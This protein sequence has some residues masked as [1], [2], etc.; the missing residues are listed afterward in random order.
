MT[1]DSQQRTEALTRLIDQLARH[2]HSAGHSEG[3]F[4]AQWAAMRYFARVPAQHRTAMHLSRFQGLAFGPVSRSVRTLIQKG[5]LVKAGSAGRGR[6][7]M[8][9]VTP[10]G[11]A[12]LERDPLRVVNSAVANLSLADRTVM[13]EGLGRVMA[14]LQTGENESYLES[15][16]LKP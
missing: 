6:A 14:A 12:L 16:T 5:Y 7:E 3:L 13:A 8:I 10:S 11:L 1:S 4:P 15:A 9:E 2:L